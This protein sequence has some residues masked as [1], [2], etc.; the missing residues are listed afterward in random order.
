M[1]KA[2]SLKNLSDALDNSLYISR[3]LLHAR[4]LLSL[5]LLSRSNECEFFSLHSESAEQK[6]KDI[7]S[8]SETKQTDIDLDK[9]QVLEETTSAP[10]ARRNIN[11]IFHSNPIDFKRKTFE[12]DDEVYIKEIKLDLK[13]VIESYEKCIR[14]QLKILINLLN[15][16]LNWINSI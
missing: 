8:A 1:N 11:E 13:V 14:N 10:T 4:R 9:S 2:Q 15:F 7:L 3:A 16:N 5:F 12:N 6:A